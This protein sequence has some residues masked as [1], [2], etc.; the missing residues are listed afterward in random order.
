MRARRFLTGE[1]SFT[2][3]VCMHDRTVSIV[4]DFYTTHRRLPTYREILTL[5]RYKST[6]AAHKLMNRLVAARLV[7]RDRKGKLVPTAFF[8]GMRLLGVVEAGFPSPA[9][10]EL[11]DTLT[12]DDYLVPNREASYILKVKGDSMI[13]AGIRDGDMVIVERGVTPREGDI[14]IAE[15]DGAWTMKYYKRRGGR[16]VLEAANK[17]YRPI[18][19]QESLAIAAVVKAVVRKY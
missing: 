17:N 4:R 5:F 1:R 19:P 12:L 16:L 11:A 7:E 6:N 3:T 8:T 15:V 10:E 9:E 2:Y 14:V 18:V 13:D